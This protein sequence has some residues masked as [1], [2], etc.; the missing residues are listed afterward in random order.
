MFAFLL[1]ASG[2]LII[3]IYLAIAV[4][5]VRLRRQAEREGK[6]PSPLPMWLFPGLSYFA[7]AGMVAVLIAM[8]TTPS[9][10][11]EFWTSAV[12]V[13]VALAAYVFIRWNRQ[14]RD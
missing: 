5:Q 3:Y 12:S 8:A 4:S 6:P 11:L 9:H 2:A 13:A 7:I 1:N 14:R 10:F